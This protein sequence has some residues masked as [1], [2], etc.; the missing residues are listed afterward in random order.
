MRNIYVNVFEDSKKDE[1]KRLEN[2]QKI[3]NN[4]KYK[5]ILISLDPYLELEKNDIKIEEE[6]QFNNFYDEIIEKINNL[7][8]DDE[9]KKE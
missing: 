7:Q 4:P 6:S 3:L 2:E 9:N 8:L 5:S 1:K